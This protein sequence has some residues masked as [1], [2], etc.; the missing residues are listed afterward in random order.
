MV[1]KFMKEFEA[2][3]C[4]ICKKDYIISYGAS[5]CEER[6][7]RKEKQ[8]KCKH[9]HIVYKFKIVDDDDYD[10][11]YGYLYKCCKECAKHFGNVEKDIEDILKYVSQDNLKELYGD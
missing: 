6:H 2:Y 11:S 7:L 3:R 4:S 1:E 8:E 9:E 5:N 10:S